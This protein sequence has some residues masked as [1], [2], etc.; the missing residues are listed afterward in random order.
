MFH[1]N[2]KPVVTSRPY[3]VEIGPA[4]A[5]SSWTYMAKVQPLDGSVP[6]A[7]AFGNNLHQVNREADK[8]IA[9][10]ERGRTITKQTRVVGGAS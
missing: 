5:S 6:S 4:L 2:R 7:F 10:F 9:R 3:V 1:R 8:V